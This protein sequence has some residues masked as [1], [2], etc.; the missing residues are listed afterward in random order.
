MRQQVRPYEE[1]GMDLQDS[2]GLFTSFRINQVTVAL[3]I[4]LSDGA[5]S[6]HKGSHLKDTVKH[7]FFDWPSGYLFPGQ[8]T[9]DTI[10]SWSRL[11]T[12]YNLSTAW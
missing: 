5:C 2:T 10:K 7:T 1:G 11:L 6:R 3:G 4:P 12:E 8:A 9:A